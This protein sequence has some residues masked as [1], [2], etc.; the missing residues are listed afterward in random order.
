[1]YTTTGKTRKRLEGK[2]ALKKVKCRHH[3]NSILDIQIPKNN[4]VFLLPFT[5]KERLKS[6]ALLLA[7]S[8][9]LWYSSTKEGHRPQSGQPTWLAISLPGIRRRYKVGLFIYA[10]YPIDIDKQC[11]EK[12]TSRK[13]QA[14]YF[15][16]THM[17]HLPLSYFPRWDYAEWHSGEFRFLKVREATTL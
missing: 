15:V 2:S 6:L 13:Q 5:Q 3:L 1:M 14:Q 10:C 4:L 8:I 12:S 7:F 17:H 9:L 11:N 16:C